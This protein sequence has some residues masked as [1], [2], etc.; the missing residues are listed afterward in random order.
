MK[1]DFSVL[2]VDDEPLNLMLFQCTFSKKY[3]V[4]TAS[5]GKEALDILS[6]NP[7][8]KFTISDMK[9]PGMDGLE[10][11]TEAK[12]LHPDVLYFILTGYDINVSIEEALK[13]NLIKNHFRKPLKF[14]DIDKSLK[15]LID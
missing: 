15:E 10:F 4:I 2:Y 7:S 5:S 3:E 13:N 14:S 12:R 9:M 6:I 1:S 8:I 11:I